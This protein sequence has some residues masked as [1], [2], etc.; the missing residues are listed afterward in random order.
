MQ[1]LPDAD[2]IV[3]I[4]IFIKKILDEEGSKSTFISI[5]DA[6]PNNVCEV[7]YALTTSN[8][9]HKFFIKFKTTDTAGHE[10]DIRKFLNGQIDFNITADTPEGEKNIVICNLPSYGLYNDEFTPDNA[11]FELFDNLLVY[12]SQNF[13]SEINLTDKSLGL[14][15]TD[16]ILFKLKINKRPVTD[17][18]NP[19]TNKLLSGQYDIS[20]NIHKIN[21]LMAIDNQY[22]KII[23]SSD[24]KNDVFNIMYYDEDTIDAMCC[25][26][27][28][29]SQLCAKIPLCDRI[30]PRYCKANPSYEHCDCI[31]M[32][33]HPSTCKKCTGYRTG[34]FKQYC[35][36]QDYL[37]NKPDNDS[38][39]PNHYIDAIRDEILGKDSN[40]NYIYYYIGIFILIIAIVVFSYRRIESK[41]S[42]I[43]SI[44]S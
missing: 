27:E 38:D 43:K 3:K 28:I 5:R 13:S 16:G 24:Q 44:S 7:P 22:D 32:G 1:I 37:E 34:E 11:V 30:M 33:K 29:D 20:F 42:Q 2:G 41:P 6:D 23:L 9:P 18:G 31:R 10:V 12:R 25:T 17:T 26:N 8:Y 39:R 19:S 15:D 4:P 21:A 14:S 36:K 35:A 40:S